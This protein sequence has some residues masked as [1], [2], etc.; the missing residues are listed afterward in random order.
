MHH[1]TF[2]RLLLLSFTVFSSVSCD[3]LWRTGEKGILK[4]VL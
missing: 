4:V 3:S 2:V 1:G